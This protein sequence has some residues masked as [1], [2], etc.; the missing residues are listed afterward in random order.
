ML[1]AELPKRSECHHDFM[2]F[3]F[4]SSITELVLSPLFLKIGGGTIL[5]WLQTEKKTIPYREDFAV[6]HIKIMLNCFQLR[7]LI[8]SDLQYVKPVC[9]FFS[10]RPELS[11]PPDFAIYATRMLSQHASFY[12]LLRNKGAITS[13]NTIRKRKKT[14]TICF[15]TQ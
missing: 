9:F 3:S 12:L 13:S 1:V 4:F 7:M 15:W 11:F 14:K 2:W 6:R 8:C 10:Q 5:N